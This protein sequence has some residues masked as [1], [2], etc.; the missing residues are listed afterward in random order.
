MVFSFFLLQ[1]FY[2]NQSLACGPCLPVTR[3][4]TAWEVE[5]VAAVKSRRFWRDGTEIDDDGIDGNDNDLRVVSKVFNDEAEDDEREVFK[6]LSDNEDDARA[7][8]RTTS[9]SLITALSF[10]STGRASESTLEDD[11]DARAVLKDLSEDAEDDARAVL[12]VFNARDDDAR[13]DL[14]MAPTS[15]S[16]AS[17]DFSVLCV[18]KSTAEEEDAR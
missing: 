2:W 8:F 4:N 12:K 18:I 5:R 1:F 11:N 13:A 10:F 9:R 6:A 3:R 17:R 7:A 16:I 15:F 14:R